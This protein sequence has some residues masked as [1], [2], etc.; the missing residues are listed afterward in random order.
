VFAIA[1]NLLIDWYRKKK[2]LPLWIAERIPSREDVEEQA[3]KNEAKGEVWNALFHL[4]K[5]ER[6]LI[7]LRYFEEM[8]YGEIAQVVGKNEGTVRVRI[9][10]I[11]K[12]LKKHMK[13]V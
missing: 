1:R 9:Y 2:P 4:R 8:P 6:H 7:I 5:E 12:T 11:L 13:K 10:R 3:I